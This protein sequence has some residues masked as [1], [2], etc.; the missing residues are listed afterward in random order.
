MTANKL[1]NWH[2]NGRAFLKQMHYYDQQL[3]KNRSPE[4][5]PA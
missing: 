4:L 2:R 5:W 3:Y 1:H